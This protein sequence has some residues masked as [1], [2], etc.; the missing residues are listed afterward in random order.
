VLRR[1]CVD[2][3]DGGVDDGLTLCMKAILDPATRLGRGAA[4]TEADEQGG[5]GR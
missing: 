3:E 1:R 2:L 5:V 4:P